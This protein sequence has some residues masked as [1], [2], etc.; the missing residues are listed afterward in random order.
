LRGS[1]REPVRCA[2]ALVAEHPV[3]APVGAILPRPTWIDLR[4]IHA[5]E[6]ATSAREGA[7]EERKAPKPTP[8][9][10]ADPDGAG[11][12]GVLA[13]TEIKAPG[14]PGAR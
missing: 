13:R 6:V 3:D 12:P 2:E 9:I 1:R 14:L 5:D 11:D 7:R 10:A 4:R 8:R